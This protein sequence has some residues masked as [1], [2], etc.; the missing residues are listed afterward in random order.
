VNLYLKIIN[1][2]QQTA[3]QEKMGEVVGYA[4][5]LIRHVVDPHQRARYLLN[6]ALYQPKGAEKEVADLALEPIR[7]LPESTDAEIHAKG[8]LLWALH[9]SCTPESAKEALQILESL[10]GKVTDPAKRVETGMMILG[11]YNQ[12]KYDNRVRVVFWKIS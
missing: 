8:G 4:F 6:L 10:Y 11:L 3:E 2:Y 12:K 1:A 7:A 5:P 9:Q